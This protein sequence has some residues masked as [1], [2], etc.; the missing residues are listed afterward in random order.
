MS[1]KAL[2]QSCCRDPSGALSRVYSFLYWF[3]L[4]F[5]GF[6]SRVCLHDAFVDIWLWPSA[7][8]LRIQL[9][10]SEHATLAVLCKRR[11]A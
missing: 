6:R 9:C 3:E 5:S 7:A 4:R 11:R 1:R 2:K 8:F 10:P